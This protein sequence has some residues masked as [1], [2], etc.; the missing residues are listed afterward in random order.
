MHN[1]ILSRVKAETTHSLA[2]FASGKD[3]SISIVGS[4][5]QTDYPIWIGKTSSDKQGMARLRKERDALLY[6]QP[7]SKALHIPSLL[8]FEESE[9][10][11]CL[12]QSGV[13]GFPSQFETEGRSELPGEAFQALEWL[14]RFQT[15]VRA[16]E[17]LTLKAMLDRLLQQLQ[18][19]HFQNAAVDGLVEV[20]KQDQPSAGF[21]PCAT[22][23]DF[24]RGNVLFGPS[25]IGVIDWDELRSSF[26]L[27]DVLTFVLSCVP[28]RPVSVI[29]EFKYTFFST[30]ASARYLASKAKKSSLS[31]EEGRYWFYFFV[32]NRLIW[33]EFDKDWRSLLDWFRESKY[34][35][36]NCFR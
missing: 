3:E 30:S 33:K 34:P 10:E 18:S 5:N 12:I 29:E 8:H 13:G 2:R 24:W 21:T 11:T 1:A 20:L 31:P 14:E 23:G 7:W 19:P 27:E 17:K 6:L 4:Y 26:P 15:T 32:G 25:G 22:H 28:S 36:P 35:T 9:A 16:P